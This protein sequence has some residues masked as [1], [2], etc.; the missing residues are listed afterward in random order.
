MRFK[1]MV[2]W[3]MLVK[4]NEFKTAIAKQ[5]KIEC[6]TGALGRRGGKIGVEGDEKSVGL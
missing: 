5:R 3:K 1:T 4:L 6:E 2:I